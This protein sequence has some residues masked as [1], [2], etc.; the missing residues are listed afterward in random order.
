[1]GFASLYHAFGARFEAF[2][3]TG[4]IALNAAH[5]H[6][7]VSRASRFFPLLIDT[8]RPIDPRHGIPGRDSRPRLCPAG[9]R[10][11]RQRHAVP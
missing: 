5:I 11:M 4:F 10:T 7:A 6:A 3:I 1:M 8:L 9:A 2:R